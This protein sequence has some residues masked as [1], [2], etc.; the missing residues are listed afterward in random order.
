MALPLAKQA[1]AVT[2]KVK[3][4]GRPAGPHRA[5]HGYLGMIPDAAVEPVAKHSAHGRSEIF[6]AMNRLLTSVGNVLARAAYPGRVPPHRASPLN[7]LFSSPCPQ[8]LRALCRDAGGEVRKN[9]MSPNSRRGADPEVGGPEGA[10]VR[11]EPN[12]GRSFKCSV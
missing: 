12:A 9:R 11:N 8:E 2:S 3:R 5:G 10:I 6:P 4:T 7:R 1:N